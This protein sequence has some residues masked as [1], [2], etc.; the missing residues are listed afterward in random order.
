MDINRFR[1]HTGNSVITNL[2]YKNNIFI[3]D[4]KQ[5]Q[6]NA[7]ILSGSFGVQCWCC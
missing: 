2:N 5:E 4:K 6:E 3:A 7:E 1:S